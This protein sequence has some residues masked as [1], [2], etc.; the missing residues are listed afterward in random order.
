MVPETWKKWQY[1]DP[2]QAIP[3]LETIEDDLR[4]K[5]EKLRKEKFNQNTKGLV[6]EETLSEF[7]ENYLGGAFQFLVRYGVLDM[8]LKALSAFNPTENE[9]DVL[10][11]Y[12]NA[13]PRLVHCKLVP[14]DSVAFII[15]VKQTLKFPELEEDLKK[16][17]KLKELKVNDQRF[18]FNTFFPPDLI[19]RPFRVLFYYEAKANMARV[20]K[21]LETYGDSWDICV[22]L[23]QD[24]VFVNTTIPFFKR[25]HK[26]AT[27]LQD[28][29]YAL[30]KTMVYACIFIERDY[31]SSWLIFWNLIRST[32][33]TREE[34]TAN[35]GDT[36]KK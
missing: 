16:F 7:L 27:F 12:K 18:N 11:L 20:F 31:E 21:T 10:A 28:P 5:F 33:K 13:V 34:S 8:E 29:K 24:I 19:K 9:F 36:V 3:L 15:E 30:I 6:Y 22:I 14:Y 26:E 4:T 25:L 32:I 1:I 17:S 2:E 23:K 35:N